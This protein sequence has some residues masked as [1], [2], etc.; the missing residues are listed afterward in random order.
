MSVAA[1]SP[2]I[3]LV[4]PQM[5]EN[6]GMAARAMANFGLA[7]LRLVAPRDGWPPADTGPKG[8]TQAAAGATG[9]L[10]A[11]SVH[12][13]LEEAVGDLHYLFATTARERG[14]AKPVHL[15]EEGMA[16][17]AGRLA[18]GQRVGILFG[19]ERTG[20]ENDEIAIADSVLTFPVDPAF[21]SLNLAQAV[22]LVSYEWTRAR[23]GATAPFA[24]PADS[25]PAKRETVLSFFAL[26]D[27]ELERAGFFQGAR[28]PVMKRNFRNIIHKMEPTEQDI[29]TLRGAVQALIR[30]GRGRPGG[31]TKAPSRSGEEG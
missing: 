12:D 11:I 18:A 5:A 2:V 23:G 1:A 20:L 26:L 28:A 4:R 30:G 6:I 17:A 15:P 27:V 19:P 24:L 7:E 25:A 13:R 22:L 10:D 21:S 9:V 31:A 8:M 29:R 3:I 14:Q 16:L